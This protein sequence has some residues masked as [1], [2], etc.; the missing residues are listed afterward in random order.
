MDKK[1]LNI[2][3]GER[4]KTAR[5]EKGWT[6]EKLAEKINLSTQ[7]ISTI[8]RGV[9]GAS[10]ETIIN[11]CEVLNVSSEWLLCGRQAIPDSERI[12]AKIGSLSSAQLAA[13]DRITDE[14]LCLLRVTE[15]TSQ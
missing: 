6:Q 15:K 10:L 13:L 9:A 3:I 2:A 7:F 1:T 11:L 5:E 12:A 14:L 4:I 8:E